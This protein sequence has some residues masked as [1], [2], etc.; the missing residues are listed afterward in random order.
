MAFTVSTAQKT[1]FGNDRVHILD[2]TADAATQTVETGL[3][4]IVG[5]SV[6][7]ITCTTGG[8][9]IAHNSNASGVQSMGVL[10]MSGLAAADRL[11]VTVYG[12]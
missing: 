7:I 1:V 5:F 11:F 2:I 8:F 9:H 10:G 12:R 4:V 6:G 3:K